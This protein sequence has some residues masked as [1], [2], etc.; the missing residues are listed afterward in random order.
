MGT[1]RRFLANSLGFLLGGGVL[2]TG[3]K[4]RA[5]TPRDKTIESLQDSARTFVKSIH[6]EGYSY[7][8]NLGEDRVHVNLSRVKFTH[9]NNKL[10]YSI[11]DTDVRVYSGGEIEVWYKNARV[12]DAQTIADYQQKTDQVLEA[13]AE[14]NHNKLKSMLRGTGLPIDVNHLSR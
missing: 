7:D 3:C 11:G 10:K 12:N 8:V 2:T 6:G 14:A 1:R 13:V 5:D 4:Q 9:Y